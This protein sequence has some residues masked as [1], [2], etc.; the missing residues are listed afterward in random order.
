MCCVLVLCG[1]FETGNAIVI[2]GTLSAPRFCNCNNNSKRDYAM[3]NREEEL[4]GTS[5]RRHFVFHCLSLVRSHFYRD[6]SE[7]SVWSNWT[8]EVTRFPFSLGCCHGRFSR[9]VFGKTLLLRR[10][11]RGVVHR[12]LEHVCCSICIYMVHVLV[13]CLVRIAALSHGEACA[14]RIFLAFKY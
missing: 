11:S 7:R 2:F 3:V 9:A 4:E 13:E 14:G 12:M 1:S 10:A 6:C 8:N 5:T